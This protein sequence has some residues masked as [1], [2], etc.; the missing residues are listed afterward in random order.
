MTNLVEDLLDASRIQTGRFTFNFEKV[1]LSDLTKDM[2][3]RFSEQLQKAKCKLETDIK[4]G[5]Y[6]I[7]DHARLE[8]I[9]DNLL[10]NTIKYAPESSVRVFLNSDQRKIR[11]VIEDQGPGIPKDR[12]SKIFERYERAT[13]P[14]KISGL[15]LGL[16]ITK[17]VV[18]GHN[19]SIELVSDIGKGSKFIID[20]PI[21]PT[22]DRID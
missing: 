11:L 8:Q 9:V 15:G 13:A 12:Q 19:G 3:E 7:G 16:F 20:L 18:E 2:V 1:N 22:K 21:D 6:L 17:E 5:V 14:R 4:G 10:S